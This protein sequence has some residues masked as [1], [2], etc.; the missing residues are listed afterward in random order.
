[1]LDL[2]SPMCCRYILSDLLELAGYEPRERSNVAI[3]G[4]QT[5]VT[6]VLRP[7]IAHLNGTPARC[8]D[9]RRGHRYFETLHACCSG[10]AFHD[11]EGPVL[12]FS[13]PCRIL[14]TAALRMG[15]VQP[16]DLFVCV[17]HDGHDGH[18]DAAEVRVIVL[19]HA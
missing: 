9:P 7:V 15:Q 12:L 10:W 5:D 3:T 17:E 11:A 2:V 18:D 13:E 8:V 14:L 16:G 4:I 1:M 19:L 6:Q